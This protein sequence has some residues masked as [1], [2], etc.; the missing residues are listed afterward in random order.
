M[1][2]VQIKVPYPPRTKG[3]PRMTRGGR[4]YTPKET[5]E[6]EHAIADTVCAD[7]HEPFHGPVEVRIRYYKDHQTI[8]ITERARKSKLRGDVDNYVKLTLDGL[9]KSGIIKNDNQV[10]KITATKEPN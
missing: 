1:R 4:A 10:H 2:S 8:T 6:A 5:L 9:Q 7:A 3:R